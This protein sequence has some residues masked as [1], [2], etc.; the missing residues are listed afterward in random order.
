MG[1]GR[2]S[3]ETQNCHG[4]CV[5]S[6]SPGQLQ[7]AHKGE[8]ALSPSDWKEIHVLVSLRC[9]MQQDNVADK[10]RLWSL[11]SCIKNDTQGS[12][13][14]GSV[15]LLT[16]HVQ[17]RTAFELLEE[18][19][20]KWKLEWGVCP[21]SLFL[22]SL[23][24]HHL[25]PHPL[26][27][28]P[29]NWTACGS[30]M[31]YLGCLNVPLWRSAPLTTFTVSR[32]QWTL[33]Q[34][35]WNLFVQLWFPMLRWQ[36]HG[37][38][39]WDDFRCP[40]QAFNQMQISYHRCRSPNSLPHCSERLLAGEFLG[41]SQTPYSDLHRSATANVQSLYQSWETVGRTGV[42]RPG[43]SSQPAGSGMQGEEL[44]RGS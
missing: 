12:T 13:D 8:M 7:K 44:G 3:A 20:N 23:F 19:P 15:P 27:C 16:S 1:P 22:P 11:V 2:P 10:K 29:H 24:P 38:A 42:G 32:P 36:C 21:G 17:W 9:Y 28:L 26:S 35:H 43:W 5:S 14:P 31:K 39:R 33:A 18:N 41:T 30:S 4:H 34:Y 25:S 40:D 6:L 37:L